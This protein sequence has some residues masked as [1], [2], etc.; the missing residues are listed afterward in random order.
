MSG[1]GYV[2]GRPMRGEQHEPNFGDGSTVM[3]AKTMKQQSDRS[4]RYRVGGR[5]SGDRAEKAG[6]PQA[7]QEG[8]AVLC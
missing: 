7:G 4:R 8:L 2:Q 1:P 3:S 6:R 5:G